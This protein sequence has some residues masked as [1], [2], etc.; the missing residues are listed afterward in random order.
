MSRNELALP[1]GCLTWLRC[2]LDAERQTRGHPRAFLRYAELVDDPGAAIERLVAALPVSWPRPPGEVAGELQEFIDPALRTQI[3]DANAI[4]EIGDYSPWL[5]QALQFHELLASGADEKAARRG[6]DGLSTAFNAADAAFTPAIK[7][8]IKTHRAEAAKLQSLVQQQQDAIERRVAERNAE[9]A[10]LNR[11]LSESGAALDAAQARIGELEARTTAMVDEVTALQSHSAAMAREIAELRSST[12]WRITAPLRSSKRLLARLGN[13][14]FGLPLVVGWRILKTG[15]LLPLRDLRAVRT[16]ARAGLFDRAWYLA[17][18][19][20]IAATGADPIVHYV[21]FG[22]HE[23]RDPSPSFNSRNYLAH[24]LDVAAAGANPFVHFVLHGKREGRGGAGDSAPAVT[25][26][27]PPGIQFETASGVMA[28][29]MAPTEAPFNDDGYFITHFMHYTWQLR[30]DLQ[31]VF[32]LANKSSRLEFC[33]WFLLEASREYGLPAEAYSDQLLAKLTPC[34]GAVGEKAGSVL[35]EKRRLAATARSTDARAKSGAAAEPETHGASIIGYHRGEFGMGEFSRTIVRSFDA[36]GLPFSAIDYPE[37]GMHGKNDTSIEHLIGGTQRFK[38]NIFNINPDILPSLY[39]KFGEDFFA[40]HF[41]I[42]YWAW[43]LPKCPPEFDI[44]LGMV[45]EVWALS[46]FTADSL[47]TRSPVPVFSM[48][49]AVS[50]PAL[51]R[52]YT[53]RDFG[54]AEDSFTFLFTFDAASYLGRKNPIAAA[55]AFK[56]AFPR[57]TE[58]VRL[59]LKTMNVPAAAPLWD[60]LVAEA[61]SDPRIQIMNRRLGRHEIVG[62]NSVC[63][64]VVSL[65]RSEGFGLTVA[66]A[67]L[68][69]KPAVVTNYSGTRNFAR[70]DTACVVDFDLVPVPA[71]QYP[72]WQDQVWAEPDVAHAASLMRRLVDDEPY[73]RDIARAGQ[74]FVSENLNE[75]VVGARYAARLDQLRKISFSSARADRVHERRSAEEAN[76]AMAGSI[77]QPGPDT[78][79]PR[80]SAVEVSGWFASQAGIE[81]LEVFCD[82]KLV[83]QAHHGTLRAD[84]GSAYPYF[85]DAAHAAFFCIVD[86]E[87]LAAGPHQLRVVARSRSGRESELT[88][89]FRLGGLTAYAQWLKNN[90]PA[91][92]DRDALAARATRGAASPLITLLLVSQQSPDRAGIAATLRSISDQAYRR[93]EV[94]VVVPGRAPW[95]CDA[96]AQAEDIADR[97]RVVAAGDG[98]LWKEALAQARGDFIAVLEAGDVLDP[99]ALLAVAENVAEVPTID[100]L[101]ADEDRIFCDG[102]GTPRFKPSYSPIFLESRDYVGRPWF[103]RRALVSSAVDAGGTNEPEFE[104]LLIKRVGRAA[105]AVAHVPMVLLSRPDSRRDIGGCAAPPLSSE[106][107][108]DAPWPRVSIVIPT[109]LKAPDV[110][111]QCLSALAERTDYPD[112]EIIVVVNNV[113]DAQAAREFLGRWPVKALTWDRPYTWSG[114][115]NLAARHA[116][117]DHLLFLNDDVEPLSPGWLKQMVR[118]GR[119]LAVGAVGALLRYPNGTIQH[120]GITIS[121]RSGC[122]CHLFRH[123]TGRE[124][125]VAEIAG[126]TRECRAVTGACLL[127]RRE[128]FEALGG[129]DEDMQLVAN[130]IDYCLRLEERGYSTVMAAQAALT[131][132]EGLSRGATPEAGDIERFWRRWRARLSADDPFTNPNLDVHRYDWSVDPQARA[133]L[134]ARIWPQRCG[135]NERIV[136]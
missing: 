133:A 12:S 118:L 70:E 99:R 77:D 28:H 97:I 27:R 89:Q 64:A 120:G 72:F 67:M 134:T 3:A 127:T 7:H 107:A 4:D 34:G 21:M 20:D 41:N 31:P 116:G 129:F 87:R 79:I 43:E 126:Y 112:L 123:R 42:G 101:Y 60:A 38:A 35:G 108:A 9:M 95:N 119:R 66:E 103:A 2:V 39:F 122:G 24:N 8:E 111:A 57:G 104:H 46:D 18:N 55:R 117:G 75:Q 23:G 135:T 49:L 16:I 48:P 56:Q 26:L 85:K 37:A 81:S 136:R 68:L 84:V 76:D 110:V 121:N 58:K 98:G 30:P 22:V 14:A 6:I 73:R 130:D 109:C 52:Q 36:V 59:V 114:I 15:S 115:N 19:P 63:D 69:G 50:V 10:A 131:H 61:Q 62:L 54:L 74:S 32:D 105:R 1:H 25:E 113:G 44:A 124:P 100:F 102:R 90:A 5:R 125:A 86:S 82:A 33:K 51:R 47:R 65:H 91:T 93:F 80:S 132:H 53:K 96:L 106:L 83:G 94:L 92:A 128:C 17:R 88:R 45:D 71:G 40:D 29:L 13:G 78:V 11:A